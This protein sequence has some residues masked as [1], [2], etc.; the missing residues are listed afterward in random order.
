MIGREHAAV[1]LGDEVI[2]MMQIR[3]HRLIPGIVLGVKASC[4]GVTSSGDNVV[5]SYNS[6]PWLEVMSP[7]GSVLHQFQDSGAAQKFKYPDFLT[8]SSNGYIYIADYGTITKMDS[9]LTVLKTFSGPHLS[10]SYLKGITSVDDNQL[11]VCSRYENSDLH[12]DVNSGKITTIL[13]KADGILKPTSLAYCPQ[14]RILFV[15]TDKK[16]KNIQVFQID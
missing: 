2:Q 10:M 11:L 5:V 8:T 4:W 16:T 6:P 14:Q 12:V 9:S 15:C 13:G 1:A 3:G 7:D